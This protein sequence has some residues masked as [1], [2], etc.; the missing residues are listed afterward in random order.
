MNCC[1][2]CFSQKYLVS[3]NRNLD[4]S[5]NG[6]QNFY[7]LTCINK[8]LYQVFGNKT[9]SILEK[10]SELQ[11]AEYHLKQKK[12][13]T[14]LEIEKIVKINKGSEFTITFIDKK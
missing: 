8:S 5:E 13:A 11:D 9:V 6:G 10:M 14:D 1:A 7:C 3:F 4:W 2:I 12:I